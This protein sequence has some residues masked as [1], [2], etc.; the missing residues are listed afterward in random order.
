M[1]SEEVRR[2]EWKEKEEQG[3]NLNKEC[4]YDAC[5]EKKSN[6]CLGM[7]RRISRKEN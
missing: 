7:E 2:R 5:R 6:R 3:E 1:M 4:R